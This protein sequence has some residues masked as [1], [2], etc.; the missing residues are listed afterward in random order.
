MILILSFFL[1]LV[2]DEAISKRVEAHFVIADPKGA[3]DDVNAALV[4]APDHPDLLYSKI[5][6]LARLQDES[7]MLSA[8]NQFKMRFPKEA[9]QPEL[10]EEIAWATIYKGKQDRSPLVRMESALSAFTT[11]DSRSVLLLREILE[12]Q[13]VG[14]RLFGLFLS[15][16][17]RDELLER[18]V[19]EL[20]QEDPSPLVR[21]A[22]VDTLRAMRA[23]TA[24]P[25]LRE[26]LK[27]PESNREIKQAALTALATLEFPIGRAEIQEL[28]ESNHSTLRALGC[29]I[30]LIEQLHD[31]I[32]LVKIGLNDP[33][34]DVQMIAM[35]AL[36]ALHAELTESEQIQ[37]LD[38]SER[39]APHNAILASFL[40]FTQGTNEAKK[41]GEIVL[42]KWLYS[43]Q[44]ELRHLA[45][46]AIAHT[47]IQGI[48][49]SKEGLTTTTDLIVAMNLA[50]HLI[51][52]RQHVEIATQA[53]QKGLT[54]VKERL[55][56]QR[57]GFFSFITLGTLPHIAHIPRYP[58]NKDLACRLDLYGI[59]ATCK[60]A[61]LEEL[62]KN[63]FK[64][65]SWGI[66]A[67]AALL[68][69][70]EG[71]D[72]ALD[73]IKNLLN[74]EILEVRVQAAFVLAIMT[75]D[76][77]ARAVLQEAYT[78]APREMKEQILIGIGAIGSRDSLHFLCSVL[79]ESSPVLRLRASG[80]ILQC[81]YH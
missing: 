15:M 3:L 46:A 42:K 60:I 57:D 37:L 5:R 40:L 67:T 70:Q 62:I 58:E 4:H 45:A 63:F 23:K 12:D 41:A 48:Q 34:Q 28:I 74:S 53:I 43:S 30:V 61:N 80:A 47:G 72:H 66:S 54:T 29:Q 17:M 39:G 81:L 13:N 75:Q 65:R 64:E 20:F 24:K 78:I 27:N 44:P 11:Q 52:Q 7:A 36:G 73:V 59:L 9:T 19:L 68:M 55:D 18:K 31:C 21:R 71:N 10:L 6:C 69:I 38:Y 32:D 56:W 79:D 33:S 25:A 49:L 1:V 16:Q 51:K 26:L 76:S 22:A 14:L 77:K 35:Q 2:P 50:I 8:W